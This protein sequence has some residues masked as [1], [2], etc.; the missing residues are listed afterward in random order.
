MM[1][2]PDLGV[3]FARNAACARVRNKR[4][5]GCVYSKRFFAW[6]AGAARGGEPVEQDG[7]GGQQKTRK[8]QAA[9]G[10]PVRLDGAA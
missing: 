9:Y 1:S 5:S 3:G 7:R 8:Q 10:F 2:A 4:S 6:G